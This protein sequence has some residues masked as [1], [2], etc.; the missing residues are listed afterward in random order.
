MKIKSKYGFGIVGCG[1]IGNYHAQAIHAMKGGELKCVF[2]IRNE[3]A[4]KLALAYGVESY[5]DIKRFLSHPGLDVVTIGTPSGL[6]LEPTLQAAEAGKHVIC[7]KPL[8]VTLERIDKMIKVC[9]KNGVVLAGVHPRRF[10]ESVKTFKRAIEKK[11]L[12]KITMA[13]AY[14]KWFRTQQYYDSGDWRGTW[15]FDGGGALMNQSIHTIDQLYHLVGDVKSVCAYASQIAHKRIEVE[16]IA[17]AILKFKNGAMG[18]IEGSTSCFSELG[19]GAEVHVCGTEGSIFMKDNSFKVWDFKKKLPSDK[20][21]IEKY[22]EKVGAVG[23]GAADPNAIS[24][25][26]HQKVFEN[27]IQ[28]IKRGTEP[29]INGKEARKSV[30]IILAIYQSALAGGKEVKLPLKK[31]PVRKVT[32]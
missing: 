26:D 22:G 31:T 1:M 24:Y 21:I 4:E 12:G 13:D 16:D 32:K 14:I 25:V 5:S 28:S 8:E 27:T 10:F 30:E 19:H 20:K 3:N 23:V 2:D 9:K 7:E 11:R 6:H 29:A 15:K 17:V 18:V